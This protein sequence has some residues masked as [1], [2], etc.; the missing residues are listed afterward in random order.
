MVKKTGRRENLMK[1]ANGKEGMGRKES[2]KM[3]TE[4]MLKMEKKEREEN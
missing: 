3:K 2:K 4:N 1:M